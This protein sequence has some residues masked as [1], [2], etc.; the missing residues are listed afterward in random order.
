MFIEILQYAFKFFYI[1]FT[2]IITVK[3]LILSPTAKFFVEY[4][5]CF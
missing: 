2:V 5:T 3:S 4:V 1:E